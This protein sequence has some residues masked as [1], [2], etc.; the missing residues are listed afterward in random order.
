M[1]LT[2]VIKRLSCGERAREPRH[3]HV[4]AWYDG[5]GQ[6]QGMPRTRFHRRLTPSEAQAWR[7]G[8]AEGWAASRERRR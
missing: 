1:S 8:W 7:E 6:A 3:L 4:V 2:N 5:W